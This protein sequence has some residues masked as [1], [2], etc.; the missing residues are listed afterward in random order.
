[1]SLQTQYPV[2][3]KK[4]EYFFSPILSKANKRA[5]AHFKK[6][7]DKMNSK[8]FGTE[9]GFDLERSWLSF[10]SRNS[11]SINRFTSGN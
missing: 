10:Y 7:G 6:A 2:I 8:K 1:M 3:L 11:R 9:A 5:Y 4:Y